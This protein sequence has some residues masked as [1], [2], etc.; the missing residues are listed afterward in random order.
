[1]K[2][3]RNPLFVSEVLDGEICIFDPTN[4]SYFNLNST[5]SFIWRAL[6]KSKSRDEILELLFKEY[7]IKL[8]DKR[9]VLAFIDECIKNEIFIEKN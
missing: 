6:T 5:G 7:K 4:A 2:I 1:M 8:E 3:A 9:E